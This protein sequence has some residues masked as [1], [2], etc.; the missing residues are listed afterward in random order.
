MLVPQPNPA[1][2][3]SAG[4]KVQQ[5]AYLTDELSGGVL[6]LETA[7]LQTLVRNSVAIAALLAPTGTRPP[8]YLTTSTALT[9]C[10][11][12]V[13]DLIKDS[14]PYQCDEDLSASLG[15]IDYQNLQADI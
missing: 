3:S 5:S 9:F 7:L 10:E 4:G 6:E 15:S 11:K 8:P 1:L 14:W 2:Y 12:L 13:L